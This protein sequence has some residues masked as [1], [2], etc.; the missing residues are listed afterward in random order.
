MYRESTIY[1]PTSISMEGMT[2]PCKGVERISDVV[3]SIT[4]FGV[5][6]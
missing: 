5:V 2:N 4:L 1:T 6:Y 3:G